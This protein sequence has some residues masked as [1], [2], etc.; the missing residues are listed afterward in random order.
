MTERS[1][2]IDGQTMTERELADYFLLLLER[3]SHM[4]LRQQS[5]A[6]KRAKVPNESDFCARCHSL[7]WGATCEDCKATPRAAPKK[8]PPVRPTTKGRD[9][10]G[11]DLE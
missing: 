4:Q 8:M 11:I 3:E 1:Y 5:E 10:R 2:P 7:T 6:P 9:V